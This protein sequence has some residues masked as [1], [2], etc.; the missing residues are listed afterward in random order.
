MGDSG[1]RG[2]PAGQAFPELR[3]GLKSRSLQILL[4][5]MSVNLRDSPEIDAQGIGA[6]W[7]Q[8]GQF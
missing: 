4:W 3:R 7:N 2:V 6:T 5:R 8:R 1:E